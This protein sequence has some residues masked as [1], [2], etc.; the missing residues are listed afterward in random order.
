MDQIRGIFR[1]INSRRRIGDPATIDGSRE[2][3]TTDESGYDGVIPPRNEK[4]IRSTPPLLGR[5]G[6]QVLKNPKQ[7]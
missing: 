7:L 4:V 2:A 5:D 1:G 6:R 3:Q